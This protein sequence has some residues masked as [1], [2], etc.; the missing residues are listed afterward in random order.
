VIAEVARE[1]RVV[2]TH[3][4][5][6]HVGLL[7]QR[8]EADEGLW[9]ETLDVLGA[10]TEGMIG[11]PLER[12]IRNH[13][14]DRPVATLLTQVVVDP[15]D[16][17]FL[18]PTKPIGSVYAREEAERLAR[19]RGWTIAPDGAGWRRVVPSPDPIRIVELESVR[20]LV[21][22]GHVVVCVGGGGVPVREAPDGALVG[23][24]AVIDKDLATSLLAIGL[25]AD[26]LCLLTDVRGVIAE[27]PSS[28]EPIRSLTV[29]E[30]RGLDLASGSMGPK[31]LAASRFAEATGRAAVIGAMED[32][33]ALVAGA[34][35][36]RVVR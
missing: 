18:E 27:W 26:V 31:V 32:A 9:Q 4:S 8:A 13:L 10:E 23:V 22:A 1:H 11:Y 16:P 2:V 15:R 12:E 29:A 7:A 28:G 21:D 30:A 24:E 3:G 35:G 6:P 20:A 36:T 17:A 14:R 19:E 33:R 25:D 5:G 34:A